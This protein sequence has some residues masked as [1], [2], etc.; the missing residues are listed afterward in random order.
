MNSLK[1][2]NFIENKCNEREEKTMADTPKFDPEKLPGT[3]GEFFS[4]YLPVTAASLVASLLFPLSQPWDAFD[5]DMILFFAVSTSLTFMFKLLLPDVLKVISRQ[6][7]L[8]QSSFGLP[9]A[10]MR[11]RGRVRKHVLADFGITE[12]MLRSEKECD[13]AIKK[14]KET[15]NTIGYFRSFDPGVSQL[16]KELKSNEARLKRREKE[17]ENEIEIAFLQNTNHGASVQTFIGDLNKGKD[18]RMVDTVTET[19]KSLK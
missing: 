18:I 9:E 5:H 1:W 8:V 14:C 6:I 13:D 11:L 4:T 15:R 10:S 19:N 12:N 3:I 7:N 17:I 2:N 16:I